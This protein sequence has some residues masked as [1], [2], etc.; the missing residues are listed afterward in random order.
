MNLADERVVER[1]GRFRLALEPLARH[2]VGLELVAD[3]VRAGASAVAGLCDDGW[4]EAVVE[5]G[6]PLSWRDAI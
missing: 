2:P 3:Q 1:G 5:L 6:V 4:R